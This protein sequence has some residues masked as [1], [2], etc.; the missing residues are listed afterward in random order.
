MVSSK[1][2]PATSTN[3]VTSRRRAATGIVGRARDAN[4]SRAPAMITT[5]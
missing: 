2:P 1:K 4:I 3:G 5:K